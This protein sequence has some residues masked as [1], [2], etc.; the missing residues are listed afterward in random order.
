MHVSLF[1]HTQSMHV[2]FKNKKEIHKILTGFMHW[3]TIGIFCLPLNKFLTF[4]SS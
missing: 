3:E 4:P 1:I 2:F